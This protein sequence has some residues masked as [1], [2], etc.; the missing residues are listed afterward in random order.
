MLVP[1][2]VVMHESGSQVGS[3]TVLVELVNERHAADGPTCAGGPDL[4][5]LSSR[6]WTALGVI[7]LG[8]GWKAVT[9]SAAA[10]LDPA[11]LE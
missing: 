7:V 6:S 10:G 8:K 4:G 5:S 9:E 2:F 3:G 11:G 1:V